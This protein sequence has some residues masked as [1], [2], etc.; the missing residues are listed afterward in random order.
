MNKTVS[1]K[2]GVLLNKNQQIKYPLVFK[3]ILMVIVLQILS[4]CFLSL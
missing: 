4:S 3:K 2:I 1:I